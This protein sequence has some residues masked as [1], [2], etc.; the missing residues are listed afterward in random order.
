MN[1]A[2]ECLPV[3]NALIPNHLLL[4]SITLAFKEGKI[5]PKVYALKDNT[6]KKAQ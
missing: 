4:F 2:Y 5:C 6:T 3:S 1:F